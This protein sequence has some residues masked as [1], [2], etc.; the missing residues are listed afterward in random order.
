MIWYTV[1]WKWVGILILFIDV[2]CILKRPFDT[3][4][5]VVIWLENGCV[6]VQQKMLLS[7]ECVCGMLIIILTIS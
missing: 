3:I 4:N 6:T 7:C 2:K 5:N 1:H